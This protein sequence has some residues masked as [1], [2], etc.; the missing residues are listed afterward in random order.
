MLSSMTRIPCVFTALLVLA[1]GADVH[2]AA[3]AGE[4]GGLV[5]MIAKLVNF[6]ILAGLLA[7]FL[8]SPLMAYLAARITQ[9]RQDL[10]TASQQRAAAGAQ[11]AQIAQRMR[12]L[13]AELEALKQRGAEDVQAERTRI[14]SAAAAERERLLAQ[15]RREIESRLRIAKREL[16]AHTAEL[17]VTVARRRIEQSI[18]AADQ[19][20]LLDRYATQLGEGR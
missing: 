7:Y 19:L 20:R 11:L 9:I 10:V 12:A 14:A 5:S 18:T 2:A 17:A 3:Q 13:P 16:A 8:K 1:L 6:A 15:T 4:G